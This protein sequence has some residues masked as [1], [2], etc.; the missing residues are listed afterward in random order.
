MK[1]ASGD[2]DTRGAIAEALNRICATDEQVD[3]LSN[4]IPQVFPEWP[5]VY[6]LRACACSM[7]RPADGI[8]ADSA[9][10]PEGIPTPSE[11][12]FPE[13]KAIPPAARR[14]DLPLSEQIKAARQLE[15]SKR[16]M[17]AASPEL[18]SLVKDLATAV[19]MPTPRR[20]RSIAEIEAELYKKR[21]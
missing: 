21:S 20:P 9:I 8:N 3:K 12:K 1:F 16:R 15:A 17:I 10:Y 2:P 4:H 13:L 18:E 19:T 6:E 7:F 14:L 11:L 5:G